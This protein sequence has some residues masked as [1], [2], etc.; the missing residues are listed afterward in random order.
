MLQLT[1][2]RGSVL[3]EAIPSTSRHG[4]ARALPAKDILGHVCPELQLS[5]LKMAQP[6]VKVCADM[7]DS[8]RARNTPRNSDIR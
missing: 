3:E 7:N 6:G 2:L 8:E 4:A 5:A 1:T